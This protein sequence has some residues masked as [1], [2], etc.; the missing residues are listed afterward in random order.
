MLQSLDLRASMV[1]NGSRIKNESAPKRQE[2]TIYFLLTAALNKSPKRCRQYARSIQ[3]L[4]N[5]TK[6][7]LTQKSYKIV[8]VEGN[9]RRKTCLENDW[10]VE[11]LYTNNSRVKT[12]GNYGT[13]E[14]LDVT[15]AISYFDM[16]DTDFLVKMTGR[17]YLDQNSPFLFTLNEMDLQETRAIVKFGS[18]LEPSNQ[19]MKDCITG[20]IMLPVSSIPVIWQYWNQLPVSNKKDP[21]EW[22]WAA[23]ALALPP[24]QVLALQGTMGI[25]ISPMQDDNFRL[26]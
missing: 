3:I 9:G 13:N 10:G 6:H 12:G 2:P 26:V 16:K 11:V 25:Y 1:V 7:M 14:L 4:L 21:I 22:Q 23:A 18:F 19:P 20:L 17:Y 24:D 15:D 5:E 8:Y